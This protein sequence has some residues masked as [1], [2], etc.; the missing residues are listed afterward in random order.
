[1]SRATFWAPKPNAR[2]AASATGEHRVDYDGDPCHGGQDVAAGR[3]PDDPSQEVCQKRRQDQY[4]HGGY[5]VQDVGDKLSEN[6]GD[7]PY[8]QSVSGHH[9]GYDE[10]EP[11]NQRAQYGGGRLAGFRSL[12]KLPYA[13]ALHPVFKAYGPEEP[14]DYSLKELGHYVA[15]DQYED[16]ADQ[17]WYVAEK[18]AQALLE[19]LNHQALLSSLF[20]PTNLRRPL[21]SPC[22]IM[23]TL[24]VPTRF[25]SAI[26]SLPQTTVAT[27]K[28]SL[29]NRVD[30]HL[31]A[32]SLIHPLLSHIERLKPRER[33]STE[34]RLYGVLRSSPVARSRVRAVLRAALTSCGG[35]ARG[36]RAVIPRL[37]RRV[38]WCRPGRSLRPVDLTPGLSSPHLR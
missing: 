33:S 1:M 17:L 4:Q 23:R 5:D 16:G 31:S 32:E 22:S 3:A 7:L 38:G 28:G 26:H 19:L 10:N 18:G 36:W 24:Q 2:T 12:E 29:R 11:E 37:A 27:L 35:S 15:D 14:T 20:W 34:L 9:D 21:S 30:A 6:H 13:A 8:P 25:V